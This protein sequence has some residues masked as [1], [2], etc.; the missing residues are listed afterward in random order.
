VSVQHYLKAMS[1]PHAEALARMLA[2]I[3]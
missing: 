2:P 3:E 1:H